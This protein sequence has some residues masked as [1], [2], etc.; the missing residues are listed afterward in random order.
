MTILPKAIYR[1]NAI[2]MKLPMAFFTE[3]EQKFSQFVWKH[4]RPW[5]ANA[6]LRTKN[7]AGGIRLSDFRLYYKATVIKTVWYWWK[8][9]QIHEWNRTESPE[10][11]PESLWQRLVFDKEAKAIQWRKDSIFNKWCRHN[12]TSTFKKKNN[13][14]N[15]VADL[16]PSTKT[17]SSHR[18]GMNLYKTHIW[19]RTGIRISKELLKCNNKK[20]TQFFKGQKIMDISPKMYSWQINIWKD[21]K[22]RMSLGDCK[23]QQDTISHLLEWLQFKTITPPSARED[24]EQQEF[25]FTADGN[26]EWYFGRQFDSLL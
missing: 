19:E 15:L 14:N 21:A 23:F 4:K 3:L 12:C 24:V 5:I 7:G 13:N 20:T 11:D 1:F 2:S 17:N 26:A 18:L 6:I 9:R 22:P 10:I 8:N 25:S 16:T